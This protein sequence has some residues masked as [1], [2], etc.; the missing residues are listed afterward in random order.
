[1]E[2]T[3]VSTHAE[4]STVVSF[5]TDPACPWAWITSRWLAAVAPRRNLDIRWRSFSPVVRDGGLRLAPAI[6]AQLR[7]V[8]MA[9]KALG[10]T[11]LRVFEVV[12]SQHGEE[13]VGRFYTEL[14]RRLNYPGRPPAAPP[15]DLLCTSLIAAALDPDFVAV[16]ADAYWLAQVIRSTE[17]A[18]A[19]V[20]RD[21]MTPVLVLEGATPKGLSG[22]VMS[23]V[24]TGDSALRVWDAFRVLLE[25]TSFLG[26]RRNRTLP[27]QFPAIG[28]LRLEHPGNTIREEQ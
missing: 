2:V 21:A 18:M 25:Q 24:E 28:E 12:R 16:A 1:L 23:L 10:E 26:A 7:E 3:S 5:Y 6:P 17:S 20:G 9:R 13:A 8:A 22:P 15:T 19:I 27:P 11:A 14:G 4:I